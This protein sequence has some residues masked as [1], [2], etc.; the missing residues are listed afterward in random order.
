MNDFIELIQKT[1]GL[2]G[3]LTLIPALAATVLYRDGRRKEKEHEKEIRLLNQA[4]EEKLERLQNQRVS[5]AQAISTKLVGIVSDQSSLNKETNLALGRI[6][7]TMTHLNGA[8]LQLQTIV[9]N[10]KRE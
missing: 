5:D 2:A 8:L 1:Y 6:S 7:E 4:S 10:L 3:I 9:L